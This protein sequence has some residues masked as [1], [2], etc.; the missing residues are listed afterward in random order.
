MGKIKL[1]ELQVSGEN[2]LTSSIKFGKKLTII[3]GPSD[4][5]KT[6]IYKCIDYIFGA[7]N[8]AKK[9]PLDIQ[10][11]YDTIRLLINSEYGQIKLIRKLNSNITLVESKNKN[12]ESGE[13]VI[14]AGVKNT[15]T[16][17]SLIMKLMDAPSNL[18]LPKNQKGETASFTWRTI[19]SIFMLDEQKSDKVD[20]VLSKN[21][22]ETLFLAGLVFLFSGDE[23]IEYRNDDESETIKKAKRNAVIGY[24]KKQR[25]L[26]E[27]KK[28]KFEKHIKGYSTEKSLEDQI[29]ELNAT[30]DK[31]NDE[32]DSASLRHKSINEALI[33]IQNR[34]V[35]DKTTIARYNNLKKQYDTDINRLTFIVE[36]ELLVNEEKANTKCPFC[37][38]NIVPHDH[39]SYIEASQAE[40]VKL[41][42][43]LNELESTKIELKNRLDD[44]R[45]QVTDYKEQLDEINTL[46][47]QQLIPQRSQI[48]ALLKNYQERI[49]IESAL[50]QFKDFDSMYQEDIAEYQKVK[51][52]EFEAFKGKEHLYNIIND[53]ITTIYKSIL[54]EIGYTPLTQV[55]LD[56]KTLEFIVNSK[57]KYNHGKGYTA[58]FNA[59]FM[60]SLMKY[61][62]K[63]SENNLGLF[64]YDSPLKG[65]SLSEEIVNNNN[66]RAGYFNYLLNLET[67]NQIIVMENTDQHEVPSTTNRDDT[68]IYKF[69]QIEG[70]GIYGFLKD[71]R[72][73]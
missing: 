27:T 15:K 61:I 72:R 45:D 68:K 59:I 55:E 30:L 9:Q 42:T 4:T 6:Y 43:N 47:K 44:D 48:S 20:S 69:T 41:V 54:E 16:M 39:S 53:D 57:M 2:V 25:A 19:K 1:V 37:E 22:N 29:S 71:V 50:K 13:Y 56:V 7:K 58:F 17:N 70:E 11:G 26:L 52:S 33:P 28:S 24:I 32:I 34:L 49:Q 60:L 63:H 23:L 67:D 64:I 3:S 35:R 10:E 62:S 73:K 51:K 5:G 12:I 31:V 8:D 21:N 65:L 36:N 40:L 46:L 66:I 14:K 18:K 38:N